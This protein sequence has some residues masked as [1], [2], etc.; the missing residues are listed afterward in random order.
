VLVLLTT[1]EVNFFYSEGYYEVAISR[2]HLHKIATPPG[3]SK[4]C[5]QTES[6]LV[7]SISFLLTIA[8]FVV[9]SLRFVPKRIGISFSDDTHSLC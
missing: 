7:R 2:C 4:F 3:I 8:P 1:L 6:W 5:V 9:G